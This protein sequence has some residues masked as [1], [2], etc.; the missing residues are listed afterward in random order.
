MTN[1][2]VAKNFARGDNKGHTENMYIE[3]NT[4]YSYGSHF[5]IAVRTGKTTE[6]GGGEIV[7]FNSDG[8]SNTTRRHESHVRSALHNGW[9]Q[10]IEVPT[11]ILK[12]YIYAHN[13]GVVGIRIS[14][15]ATEYLTKKEQELWLKA[16]RARKLHTKEWLTEQ[17][18]DVK[19]Q[20]SLFVN[21]MVSL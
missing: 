19:H 15:M 7:L 21:R 9:Y 20:K 16:Q 4:I 2:D 14:S 8:Y 10:L 3:G 5:P 17:A 11:E 1:Q 6:V 13:N 18:M 12:E